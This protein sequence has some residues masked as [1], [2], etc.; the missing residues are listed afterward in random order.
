MKAVLSNRIYLDVTPE[1]QDELDKELTY[2]VP[3]KIQ[4]T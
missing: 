1:I 3:Q 2:V 4:E